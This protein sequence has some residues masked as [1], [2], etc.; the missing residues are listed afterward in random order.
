MAKEVCKICG[1]EERIEIDKNDIFL[2]TDSRDQKFIN[3]KNYIC[4]NCG[5]IYH[6]PEIDNKKLVK[7]YQTKYRNSDA[8]INLTKS[9]IDLPLNF[10]WISASF[11]R[12]HAFYKIIKDQKKIK[13]N[14]K[15]KILD[16]GCYHGAFL[17]ACKNVFNFKTVGTDYNTAGLKMAKSLF[18]VDEV[19]ETNK[20][21]FSKKINADIVS[22]L[23]VLEHL[24][25]PVNF[26][27]QIK[28]NIL[29]KKGLLYVEIPNP[30]SNPLDDP[31]HL[32][33]YSIDTAK[34][35]IKNCNY[36]ILHLEE[37]G[38][39]DSGLV[40]RDRNNLNIHILAQS[41]DNKKIHFEKIMIGNEIYSKLKWERKLIG[42]KIFY[43]KLKRLSKSIINT[44]VTL[45]LL[46]INLFFP[47][48][49]IKIMNFKNK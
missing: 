2:R 19:F 9:N 41:L 25:D 27:N 10:K 48:L 39:Y 5:N 40:L 1:T 22:M 29:K 8:N 17:Y 3:F 24:D 34:Y 45:I 32:N 33:V 35:L 42:L 18:S 38:V 36:K 46:I 37:K 23:H 11:H 28:K 21:F 14:K 44:V 4:A 20:K 13:F 49:L 12:F 30:F 47:N 43:E 26:L 7:Y 6:A 16:Y 31:T 15:T